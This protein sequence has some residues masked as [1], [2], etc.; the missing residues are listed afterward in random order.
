MNPLQDKNKQLCY[1]VPIEFSWSKVV[2]LVASDNHFEV[3]VKTY[4]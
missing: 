1:I 3:E 4:Y 2:G